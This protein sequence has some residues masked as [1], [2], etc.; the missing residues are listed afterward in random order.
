MINKD[1]IITTEFYKYASSKLLKSNLDKA[2]LVGLVSLLIYSKDI[3]NSN[4]D[5]GP[6]IELLFGYNYPDYIMKSRTLIVAKSSRHMNSMDSDSLSN[7]HKKI[8]I[9][10]NVKTSTN[11]QNKSTNNKKSYDKLNTWLKG[12]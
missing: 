12:F 1:D 2:E 8:S 10:L 6:F 5:I 3:F 9:Y 7:I 11:E 4:K